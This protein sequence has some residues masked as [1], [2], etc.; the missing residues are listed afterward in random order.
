MG[1]FV[2]V[3]CLGGPVL[4]GEASVQST[5]GFDLDGPGGSVRTLDKAVADLKAQRVDQATIALDGVDEV[6]VAIGHASWSEDLSPSERLRQ[7]LVGSV[8][9]RKA[10]AAFLFGIDSTSLTRIAT[11]TESRMDDRG[12]TS[13]SEKERLRFVTETVGGILHGMRVREVAIDPDG[14]RMVVVMTSTPDTAALGEALP[15][16]PNAAAA[17]EGIL[18]GMVEGSIVPCGGMMIRLDGGRAAVVGLGAMPAKKDTPSR[19]ESLV[20]GRRAAAGLVAFLQGEEIDGKDTYS[21]VFRT[22]LR[23]D[24]RTGATRDAQYTRSLDRLASTMSRGV[25]PGG[26]TPAERIG[27]LAGG[28][29]LFSVIVVPL[30]SE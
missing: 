7:T 9:A 29:Y 5:A 15:K 17:A 23:D 28:R 8:K 22:V 3:A 4:G 14:D 6:V 27:E 12:T 10:A 20:A 25:V 13:V 18:D 16:F 19:A 2:I 11:R 21:E 24:P 26:N 1:P 30:G